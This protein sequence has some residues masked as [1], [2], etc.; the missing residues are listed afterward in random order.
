MVSSANGGVIAN[1]WN[2]NADH[3]WELGIGVSFVFIFIVFI[4]GVL[5]IYYLKEIENFDPGWCGS[6]DWVL[7]CEPKGHQFNSQSGHMS[8]LRARSPA[9]GHARGNRSRKIILQR[10]DFHLQKSALRSMSPPKP[11]PLSS[12]D[13]ICTV[14]PRV[15]ALDCAMRSLGSLPWPPPSLFSLILP[16]WILLF[17]L[18]TVL[19]HKH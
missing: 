4:E 6:V 17:L 5:W 10:Q 15:P 3:A 12:R 11:P 18:I 13:T 8:G 14:R 1:A 9:G 7:D 19:S 2:V 16:L